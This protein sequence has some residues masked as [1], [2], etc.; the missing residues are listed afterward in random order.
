MALG[1]IPASG[2]WITKYF[3]VASTATFGKGD[4]VNF[5]SAY[6][7][8]DYQSTD[9][10]WVGI[11]QSASTQSTN[12]RGVNMVGVSVP[13][14]GCTM[15]SDLTTGIAQSD[16]SFGKR[17]NLYREGNNVSFTSTVIGHASRFSALLTVYGPISA[18]DSRV[19]VAPNLE[20][21]AFYSTSSVTFAS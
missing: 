20:T 8:R 4:A 5:N 14:P 17:V 6:R 12:I 7:I 13:T 19:E 3:E 18:R 21:A 2:N 11:A 15:Y 16:L 10:Q 9:S 1:L